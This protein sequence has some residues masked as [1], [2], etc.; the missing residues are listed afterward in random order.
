MKRTAYFLETILQ[1]FMCVIC[2]Y[3]IKCCHLHKTGKQIL[4]KF[5]T[6]YYCFVFKKIPSLVIQCSKVLWIA[7]FS[8]TES[9]CCWVPTNILPRF[10]EFL[11]LHICRSL[12]LNLKSQAPLQQ[13]HRYVTFLWTDK[14]M[15][16]CDFKAQRSG[17][18]KESILAKVAAETHS[19]KERKKRN[20]WLLE[21]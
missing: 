16:N 15:G 14:S 21:T 13:G 10:R 6:S 18:S 8:P 19:F 1:F 7:T 9:T 11:T 4:V 3:Y 12:K 20:I 17:C 2:M 5:N